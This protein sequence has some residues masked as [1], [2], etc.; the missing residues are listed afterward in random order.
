M[1]LGF[2]GLKRL[3]ASCGPHHM[4]NNRTLNYITNITIIITPN[5]KKI[6]QDIF[7]LSTSEDLSGVNIL[8]GTLFI[9]RH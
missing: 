6:F 1:L 2:R 9:S 8:C 7:R 4:S 3:F 5:K